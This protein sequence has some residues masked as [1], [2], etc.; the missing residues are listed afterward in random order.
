MRWRELSGSRWN[1]T[2]P[3]SSFKYD[4]RSCLA[5]VLF[6]DSLLLFPHRKFIIATGVGSK[7][8]DCYVI[9]LARTALKSKGE[10]L[11]PRSEQDPHLRLPVILLSL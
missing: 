11:V 10:R 8:C 3:R 5:K 6:P 7:S 2:T 9:Q 4:L 1:R